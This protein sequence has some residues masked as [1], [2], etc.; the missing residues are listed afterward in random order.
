M[1]DFGQLNTQVGDLYIRQMV[2]RYVSIYT[3]NA[4]LGRLYSFSNLF[5]VCLMTIDHLKFKFR[6]FCGHIA[7]CKI[8][9]LKVQDFGNFEL[10][11]MLP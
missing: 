5:S 11:P 8:G 1:W 3:Q 2:R 7:C 10:S 9:V 6:T 4:E